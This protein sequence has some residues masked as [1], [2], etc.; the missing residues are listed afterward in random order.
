M[1]I[2]RSG[3]YIRL[4]QQSDADPE[5]DNENNAADQSVANH[6][7]SLNREPDQEPVPE[8]YWPT[9]RKHALGQADPSDPPVK[10]V[11]PICWDHVSI[12]GLPRP[13]GQGKQCFIPPCG[14]IMCEECYPKKNFEEDG[15]TRVNQ[16]K[17]PLC[18][19][20]LECRQCGRSAIRERAPEYSCNIED[21][22]DISLT[23]SETQDTYEP[24][25]RECE[26]D[27][28]YGRWFKPRRRR[29]W[30]G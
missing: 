8:C 14:H 27:D 18:R 17:C 22:A 11:C 4:G 16:R 29:S 9:L 21:V 20:L 1:P 30:L 24:L 23:T 25:C 7:P 13:T 3:R 5:L 15:V 28:V 12:A 6:Q 26:G 2:L 10:G 19:L